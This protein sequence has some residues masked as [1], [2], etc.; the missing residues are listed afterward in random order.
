V[1]FGEKI[2]LRGDYRGQRDAGIEFRFRFCDDGVYY[3]VVEQKSSWRL[4]HRGK[5]LIGEIPA[6]DEYSRPR[7]VVR[8]TPEE[9]PVRPSVAYAFTLL[10]E[11][12]LPSEDVEDYLVS[13]SSRNHSLSPNVKIRSLTFARP[14]LNDYSGEDWSIE[15]ID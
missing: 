14:S 8:L 10:D 2:R 4:A 11:R 5:F 3:Y 1:L 15:R 13:T 6:I 9:V 7:T 12:A